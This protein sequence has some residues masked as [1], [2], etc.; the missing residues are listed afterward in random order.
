MKALVT[1]AKGQLGTALQATAPEGWQVVGVDLAEMDLADPQAIRDVV[2]REAPDVLFSAGAYTAVDKAESE[3]DIAQAV[4]G[5]AVGH[6]AQALAAITGGRLVQVSTD[7]IF[8]GT[9]S[10]PYPVDAEP[11]PLSVYG[12]TKLSGEA[13]AGDG[14]IICRTSWV[15]AAGGANFVRTML[16]LMAE[17]DALSVVSDQI[18]A[19]T[20]ATGLAQTLWSLSAVG[21][22]GTFHYQDAGVASWYD[23]AVAIQEE[24]LALGML[25][26]AIPI[27]PIRTADYPTPATR[28]AY[29]VLDTRDTR[30]LTGLPAIHWRTNLRTMLKE[31]Q[32]LG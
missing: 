1:G 14:A 29:S 16:R 12:A 27:T 15:Y 20:L 7:F 9:R 8:D 18:G 22:P 2:T 31:E 17:R 21:K 30:A 4:N 6:M 10:T 5:D 11:N 26:R 24:A 13:Q 25:E 28:P 32:Q 19:P 3:P 23:F